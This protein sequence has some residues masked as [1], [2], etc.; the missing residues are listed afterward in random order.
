M[1]ISDL[2]SA[3]SVL[4]LVG[5]LAKLFVDWMRSRKKDRAEGDIAVGS[6]RP[7]LVERN[8]SVADQQIVLLE[9]VNAAERASYERRIKA[10]ESDVHR[11]TRER[12]QLFGTVD[13]LR[14]QVAELTRQLDAVKTQLDAIPRPS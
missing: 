9:K 3:G 5:V 10:L 14:A 7:T 11:L 8:L 6:V 12:D 1:S 4:G 13:T 2:L